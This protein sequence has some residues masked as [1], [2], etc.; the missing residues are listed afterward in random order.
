MPESEIQDPEFQGP[1]KH[2]MMVDTVNTA[3]IATQMIT[4]LGQ[5]YLLLTLSWRQRDRHY[6]FNEDN[7]RRF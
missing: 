3:R 6:R 2:D 1:E 4:E 7:L 5:R